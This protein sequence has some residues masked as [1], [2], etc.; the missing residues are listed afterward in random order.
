VT[1]TS[2]WRAP[3]ESYVS[4]RLF[5]DFGSPPDDDEGLVRWMVGNCLDRFDGSS[6]TVLDKHFEEIQAVPQHTNPVLRKAWNAFR[7]HDAYGKIQDLKRALLKIGINARLYEDVYE[8]A[9]SL[10]NTTFWKPP[11]GRWTPDGIVAPFGSQTH[12]TAELTEPW[13]QG[14]IVKGTDVTAHTLKYFY[15]GQRAESFVL[16]PPLGRPSVRNR[17]Y[18]INK[19]KLHIAQL[20][21]YLSDRQYSDREL[22][23]IAQ[24]YSSVTG[25]LTSLMDVTLDPYIALFFASLGGVDGDIGTVFQFDRDEFLRLDTPETALLGRFTII[26]VPGIQRLHRQRGL[27]LRGIRSCT[28]RQIVPFTMRFRQKPGLVFEDAARDLTEEHLLGDADHMIPIATRAVVKGDELP[29]PNMLPDL[30]EK[31][32]SAPDVDDYLHCVTAQCD[33]GDRSDANDR[34]AL[35]RKACTLHARLQA[36]ELDQALTGAD[37]LVRSIRRLSHLAELIADAPVGDSHTFERGVCDVYLDPLQAMH[38]VRQVA[39]IKRLA[40]EIARAP[41]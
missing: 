34:L 36:A 10:T 32:F 33:I 25:V 18:E 3:Y 29:V 22:E 28:V 12:F 41:A 6:P 38:A 35:I 30:Q 7:S 19:L 15:R 37:Y 21:S 8:A 13:V 11:E 4:L 23:A 27:F 9:L 39:L 2:R 14:S 17:Q 40:G 16:E 5:A 31:S 24:H 26:H 20:R 1:G